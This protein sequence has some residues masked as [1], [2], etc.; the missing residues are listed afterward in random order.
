MDL[1][2]LRLIISIVF[3]LFQVSKDFS[4]DNYKGLKDFYDL[5]MFKWN[6]V[7][8]VW[9]KLEEWIEDEW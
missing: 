1:I 5:V 8:W 6:M 4:W 9:E 7:G 2:Y 3:F